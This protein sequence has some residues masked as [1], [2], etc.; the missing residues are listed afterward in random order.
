MESTL[1][2]HYNKIPCF[3]FPA[4]TIIWYRMFSF[5]IRSRVTSSAAAIW[6]LADIAYIAI[7]RD[8]S[9]ISRYSIA[10]FLSIIIEQ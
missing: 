10:I 3:P 5:M 7:Y 9:K 2:G 4:R 8:M 6:A 1:E